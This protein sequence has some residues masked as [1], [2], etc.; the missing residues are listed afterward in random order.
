MKEASFGIRSSDRIRSGLAISQHASGPEAPRRPCPGVRGFSKHVFGHDIG[1]LQFIVSRPQV[2]ISWLAEDP[3]TLACKEVRKRMH[4][5][6]AKRNFFA[7]WRRRS[8]GVAQSGS[9]PVLGTGGREFESL[10]PD[11][12]QHGV[13][14]FVTE[15]GRACRVCPS[16]SRVALES[17]GDSFWGVERR[18]EILP[19]VPLKMKRPDRPDRVP[20]PSGTSRE[21]LA[22]LRKRLISIDGFLNPGRSM[23]SRESAH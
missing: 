20:H 17:Q 12:H 4:K 16:G 15:R 14:T 11:Q 19:A 5:Q 2:S 8:R 9:A 23:R 13:R 18:H 21:P 6:F 7:V 1:F 10:R 22:W 3:L